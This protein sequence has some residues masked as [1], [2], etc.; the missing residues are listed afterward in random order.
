MK[1]AMS[2]M[3]LALCLA[4]AGLARADEVLFSNGDRWTGRLVSLVEGKLKFHTDLA[5]ELEVDVAN[6]LTFRTDESAELHLEDGSVLIDE[7]AT[8]ESGT[9]RTRGKGAVAEQIV[10]LAETVAINPPPPE[11]PGWEGRALAGAEFRR[12]NTIK[13][14]AYVDTQLAYE[15][16]RN[17]IELVARYKGERTTNTDTGQATTNDR[18]LYGRLLY[19]YFLN[20]KWS[21]FVTNS[22]EKDGPS[23][24]D[25]RF[26]AGTGLGYKLFDGKDFRL[27]VRAGPSWVS[28]KFK[29]SSNDNDYVAGLLS[30]DLLRKLTPTLE[31]FHDGSFLQSFD[32]IDDSLLRLQTGLRHDLTRYFFLEGKILW[33][34][35]SETSSDVERQD[36]DYILGVGYKF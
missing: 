32:E 33:E 21:W 22:G 28:E 26:I 27:K 17:R 24:L 18:N 16:D 34:W 14:S 13:D 19:E 3:G 4:F 8:A 10:R 25:L 36:V 9:V 7:V 12:G 5:G 23:D 11:V 29:D 1:L 31:F 15:T 30:W 35:E 2:A 6:V 20:E